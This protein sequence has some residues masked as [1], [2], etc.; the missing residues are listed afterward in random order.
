MSEIQEKHYGQ[1]KSFIERNQWLFSEKLE[2]GCKHIDIQNCK[3][4]SCVKVY[5]TGT[6]QVQGAESKLREALN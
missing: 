6:V 1:I 4:N 5:E 3:F 2:S